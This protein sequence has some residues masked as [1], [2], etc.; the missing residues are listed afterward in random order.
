ML[1]DMNILFHYFSSSLL[2]ATLMWFAIFGYLAHVCVVMILTHLNFKKISW[3]LLQ[4]HIV[5]LA[6]S[7]VGA[8]IISTLFFSFG[9]HVLFI[10]FALSML[11]CTSYFLCSYF[12]EKS[13]KQFQQALFIADSLL[14]GLGYLVV[15]LIQ[16]NTS[17]MG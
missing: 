11:I 8:P 16:Q 13:C 10:S 12:S 1:F 7:Y 17:I 6:I 9:I 3:P 5:S 14:T 15:I 4:F 2:Y